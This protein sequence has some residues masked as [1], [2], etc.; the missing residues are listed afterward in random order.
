MRASVHRSDGF[1]EY[2][3]EKTYRTLYMTCGGCCGRAVQ[4]KLTHLVRLLGKSESM[5]KGRIVV[6]LASCITRDN[7]HGPPCPNLQLIKTVIE[8]AGLDYRCDTRISQNAETKRTKGI[9]SS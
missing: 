8:R 2:P 1:S 9:Y 4:R 6:Q 7:V 3:T 5:E